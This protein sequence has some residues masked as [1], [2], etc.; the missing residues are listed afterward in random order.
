[1]L[2]SGAKAPGL[3]SY[4]AFANFYKLHQLLNT[5]TYLRDV[6]SVDTG[7]CVP[8]ELSIVEIKS[9]SCVISF[10]LLKMLLKCSRC[11]LIAKKN[12]NGIASFYDSIH[13]K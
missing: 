10:A 4:N 13:H 3:K 9:P 6:M 8:T 2:L 5:S 7:E 12:N 1:M 11:I